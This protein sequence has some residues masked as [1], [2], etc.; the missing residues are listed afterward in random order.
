MGREIGGYIELDTYNLPMMHD[1]GIFLN[2][3]RA[4]LLYL[5]KAKK[6]KRIALPWFCCDVV[7]DVCIRENVDIRFYFIGEDLIPLNVELFDDEWLY[8]VNYYGQLTENTIGSFKRKYKRVIVDNAQ[9]YFAEPIEKCDTLYTCRKFFGVPDGGILFSDAQPIKCYPLDE[10]FKRM[11]YILGRFERGAEEFYQ[12]AANNNSIFTDEG[13]KQ[14]SKLTM[15][16]LHG[17]DYESIKKAREKNFMFLH[18]E[19]G[20]LNQLNLRVPVGPYAYPLMIENGEKIRLKLIEKKF[21]YHVY[22]QM[23]NLMYQ[24]IH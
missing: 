20:G 23:L 8:V 7:R 2:S 12:E 5:I 19:F 16:L 22:G 1:K 4:C 17:V 18:D 15:N 24:K 10:S 11:N 21:T 6:I 9:A 3:G 14:M 13:I